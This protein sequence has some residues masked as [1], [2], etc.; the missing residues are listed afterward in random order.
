MEKN[1]LINNNRKKWT[2]HLQKGFEDG[3]VNNMSDLV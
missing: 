3:M 2:Y 1:G